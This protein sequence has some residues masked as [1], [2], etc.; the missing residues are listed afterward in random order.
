MN[1][2]MPFPDKDEARRIAAIDKA[3][4][5]KTCTSATR[6]V[7]EAKIIEKYLRGENELK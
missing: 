2:K 3:L 7:A 6:L 4:E 5:M 1:D